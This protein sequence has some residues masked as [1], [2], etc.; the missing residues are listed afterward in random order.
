MQ[1]KS[2]RGVQAEDVWAAA[3]ALVA[4]G[5]R[6][7]IERVRQKIGRGSPNTVSPMLE[8]WFSTLA[9][10]LGVDKSSD[11][12]ETLPKALL[13][14]M[15]QWWEMALLSGKEEAE[16][17]VAEIRENLTASTEALNIREIEL[18]QHK[19]V[20]AE[21]HAALEDALRAA[22]NNA[23][24]LTSRIHQMQTLT[25]SREMEIRD[26]RH[27]LTVVENERDLARRRADEEVT[28]CAKERLRYEERSEAAQHKLLQDIDRARQ[29]AKKMHADTQMLETRFQ[30]DCNR[31]QQNIRAQETDLSKTQ[32]L[33]TAQTIELKALREALAVSNI[34][35]DELRNL[36]EKHQNG[37]EST[38]ARLTEALSVRAGGQVAGRKRLVRKATRPIRTR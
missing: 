35:S 16:Q 21:R 25:D 19:K 11:E 18:S 32:E 22:V 3:D 8:T 30:T 31:L 34:R 4:E 33:A 36:L 10:R 38:I 24:E 37:S 27:R 26:I 9:S 29:A 14:A 15:K 5:L 6:P 13:Q 17:Q 2:S 23:E 12:N 1:L 7:T 20:L 28:R